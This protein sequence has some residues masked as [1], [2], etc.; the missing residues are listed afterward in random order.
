MLGDTSAAITSIQSL[1]A[2][3][4][5]WLSV[6]RPTSAESDSL[7][8]NYGLR[9]AD[10]DDALDRAAASGV[11]RRD[12]YVLALFNAPVVGSGKQSRPTASPVA[13][14]V[15][16]SFLVVVHTGEI[17][18]L[19][20]FFRQCETDEAT[21]EA[22]FDRGIAGVT[23]A[24]VQRV[25]DAA[26]ASRARVE[27]MLESAEDAGAPESGGAAGRA[28]VQAM[29]R[30]RAEAHTVRRVLAP[31]PGVI[32][33]LPGALDVPAELADEWDRLLQR[34]E[35]VLELLVDDLATIDASFLSLNTISTLTQL[36]HLRLLVVV[37]TLTLPLMVVL[38]LLAL[39]LAGPLTGQPNGYAIAVGVAGVVFL[40]VLF[41]LRRRGLL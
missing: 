35:R 12:H 36:E 33:A 10:L 18:P 27:R 19:V 38:Q 39:P 5:T 16:D 41:L 7:A 24:V 28:A 32:Q 20:R 31:L 6:E 9:R 4:L 17:R 22:T 14:F 25:V 30:T 34:A 2:N 15:G 26:A 13:L 37:A 40:G 8:R 21:R 1:T 23:Q 29:N 3:G 11:W